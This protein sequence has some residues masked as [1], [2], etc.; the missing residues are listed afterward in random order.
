MAK[1]S[2]LIAYPTVAPQLADYVIGTDTSNSNETV[3]FTLQSIADVMPATIGGSG[4]LNRIAMFTPDGLTIGD[5]KLSQS[6]PLS[7]GLYQMRF[8]DCDRFIINKPSSVTTGD[9]EY[10]IQQDGNFKVSFGW[11]DDGAGFGYIYNWAG[12]GLRLGAGTKSTL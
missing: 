5:S 12:N 2:N 8:D 7:S 6:L 9:P 3:N 11:D 1:I 10:L 4:T